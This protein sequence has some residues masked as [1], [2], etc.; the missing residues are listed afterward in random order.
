M[1][2]GVYQLLHDQNRLVIS[3]LALDASASRVDRL[4]WQGIKERFHAM[5]EVQMLIE[6]LG[7]AVSREALQK[8]EGAELAFDLAGVVI[9][10]GMESSSSS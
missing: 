9:F 5:H 2:R 6:L 8:F 3:P 10:S 7:S 1:E 4:T